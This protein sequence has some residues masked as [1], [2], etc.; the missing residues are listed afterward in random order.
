MQRSA[1]S[2]GCRWE[3]RQRRAAASID[4]IL[5]VGVL[6]PVLALAWPLCQDAVRASFAWSCRVIGSP[7]L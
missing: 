5:V 3:G 1:K 6:L 2:A 4:L 7:G